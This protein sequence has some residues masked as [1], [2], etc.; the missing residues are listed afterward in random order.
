MACVIAA[1]ASG[2]GKT[3]L[4]LA[5]TAWARCSGLTIQT[6]KVGPDYLDPQQLTAASGRPCR[7]LDQLLCG[8]DWVTKS[9]YGFSGSTDLALI[10]G[11]MGLF[12]GVGTSTEGSTAAIARQLGLPVVLV[13]DAS[14]QA[15]SLAALVQGFRNHDPE[16]TVAGVVLNRV[17]S[18][19]HQQLLKEVL[20][21]IDVKL[22]GCLP[23]NDQLNLPSRHL[24]LAPVHELQHLEARLESW[25]ALAETHLD[26]GSFRRLLNAP[27]AKTDPIHNL[28]SEQANTSNVRLRPVAVAQDDAFHFRYPETS[29]CLEALGMPIVPWKPLEDEPIPSEAEGLILPGGFPEQHAERLSQCSR[30]LA[31]LRGWFRQRPL[32][33][34]CGG[35]LLLG[36]SLTDLDGCSH[37]MAGLLP[38]QAKK[39][40]LKVGYRTLKAIKD[41]LIVR[42]GEQLIG[43]E[44][45]RWQLNKSIGKQQAALWMVEGWQV[46]QHQE[47]WN[48][49]KLHASWVHLHWASCSKILQRW[50]R[51]LDATDQE[52]K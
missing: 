39:G 32:Y 35:M 15:A 22:L 29:E 17:N 7:N 26:L 42:K 50:R 9:F 20:K 44:F 24:G 45:H 52:P 13:I 18:I 11:V 19:R 30:S 4:S 27:A 1:P 48:H 31:E 6:F 25:R 33:A 37:P 34:E 43:H 10:E 36:E 51:S 2:T 28:I 5:L 41:G 21:S 8:P 46:Q 3:I 23:R 12:D 14:G 49:R 16:L 40:T 47:G 38:F